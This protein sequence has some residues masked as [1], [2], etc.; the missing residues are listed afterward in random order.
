MKYS[1]CA[2]CIG[3]KLDEPVLSSSNKKPKWLQ[4]NNYVE[5]FIN[6]N[7]E[8]KIKKQQ[9]KTFKVSI[10]TTLNNAGKYV[11]YWASKPSTNELMTQ[12]AKDAYGNFSNS[13]ISIVQKDGTINFYIKCPQNYKTIAHGKQFEETFYRHLHF[14]LETN[15]EWDKKKIYTK[16]VTCN[17]LTLNKKN[18]IIVNAIDKKYDLFDAIH[19]N[20]SMTQK[21]LRQYILEIIKK[22]PKINKAVQKGHIEWYAVP[23]I[24]YCKNENCNAS[25]NLVKKLYKK[26]L[27]NLTIFPKGYDGIKNIKI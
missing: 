19:I 24:I 8:F 10:K 13:G 27:V 1:I 9:G 6:S 18:T 25:H 12:N 3:M 22:Y 20:H 17:T 26:G 15:K 5:D 23:F 2:S 16:I 14:V 7:T 11:L 21:Q 4:Q